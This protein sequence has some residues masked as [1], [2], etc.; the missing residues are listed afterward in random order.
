[1]WHK[2]LLSALHTQQP[3]S[4]ADLIRLSLLSPQHSF[5]CLPRMSAGFQKRRIPDY[6][7]APSTESCCLSA[8]LLLVGSPVL[9]KA[10]KRCHI[11]WQIGFH[12][13]GNPRVLHVKTQHQV[14]M[15]LAC[16]AALLPVHAGSWAETIL[17]WTKQWGDH[18]MRVRQMSACARFKYTWDS[19]RTQHP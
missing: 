16:G 10:S 1:M 15:P 3:W 8:W 4:K 12:D 6:F 7:Q 2:L 11:K 18:S 17:Q 9:E 14:A 5:P 19:V 13:T